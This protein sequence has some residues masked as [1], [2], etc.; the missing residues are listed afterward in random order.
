MTERGGESVNLLVL[1][2]LAGLL[3][4][5]GAFMLSRV[6]LDLTAEVARRLWLLASP[7]AERHERF[8]TALAAYRSATGKR[9]RKSI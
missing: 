9:K 3:A 5:L 2:L 7:G 6:A 1:I 8:R 4:G